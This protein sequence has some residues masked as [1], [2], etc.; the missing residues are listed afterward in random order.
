MPSVDDALDVD[1]LF[2]VVIADP[3]YLRSDQ[4]RRYPNDPEHAVDG[5]EDGLAEIERSLRV[6]AGHTNADGAALLQ[7]R[8]PRQVRALSVLL[9]DSR[10]PLQIEDTRTISTERSIVLLQERTSVR[11]S[12]SPSSETPE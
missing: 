5:G 1:E 8:G 2:S 10:I 11:Y 7:V 9:T 6:I 12:A 4:V 3:P